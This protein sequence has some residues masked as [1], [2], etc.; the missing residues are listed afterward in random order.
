MV[1]FNLLGDHTMAYINKGETIPTSESKDYFIDSEKEKQLIIKSNS[2]E[3]QIFTF[4]VSTNKLENNSN[5]NYDIKIDVP[6]SEAVNIKYI[7][8]LHNNPCYFSK[9]NTKCHYML[10]VEKYNKE[11]KLYLFTPDNLN[12]LIYANYI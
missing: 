3:D 11:N 4:V 10:P 8:Y 2:F 7:D 9:D 12:T 5:R 1:V 6:Y